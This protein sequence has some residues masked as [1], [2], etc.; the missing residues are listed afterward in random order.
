MLT[1][2][3]L[4]SSAN[5]QFGDSAP[6]IEREKHEFSSQAV[7]THHDFHTRLVGLDLTRLGSFGH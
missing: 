1:L 2:E 5:T 6:Y 7:C 4:H 3:F